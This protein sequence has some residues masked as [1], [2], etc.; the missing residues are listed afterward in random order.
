MTTAMVE[1][2]T[3]LRVNPT[4]NPVLY[5]DAVASKFGLLPSPA[6]SRKIASMYELNVAVTFRSKLT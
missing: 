6:I 2:R 3:G 1:F 4:G 5:D